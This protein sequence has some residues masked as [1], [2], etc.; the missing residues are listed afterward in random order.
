MEVA[1]ELPDDGAVGLVYR[2]ID[3]SFT[4]IATVFRIHNQNFYL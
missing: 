3:D 2:L 1:G 4:F